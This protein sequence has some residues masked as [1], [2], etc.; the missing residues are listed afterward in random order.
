MAD[1]I[2]TRLLAL[3]HPDAADAA[4]E[5]ERLREQLQNARMYAEQ[6]ACEI[7][8]MRAHVTWMRAYI[9][10]LTADH[11]L[12]QPYHYPFHNQEYSSWEPDVD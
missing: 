5:I 10:R 12:R 11:P 1:D 8:R 7:E 3:N 6:D 4:D 9:Q 2:V